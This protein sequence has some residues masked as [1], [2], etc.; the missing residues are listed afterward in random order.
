MP[1]LT[2]SDIAS[3]L[4]LPTPGAP[5]RPVSGV[6]TLAEASEREISFL[7]SE[8]YLDDFAASKAAAVLVQ[9][10]VKLPPDHGKLVFFVDDADLAVAKL[11]E[12]FAPPVPRPPVGRDHTA[13]VAPSAS[14][15]DGARI[16]PNVFVG[17]ACRIGKNVVLHA[18]VYV[19][20]DVTIGD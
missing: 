5:T 9:K 8:K 1:A 11:L 20:C 12:H 10:R 17:D 13:C 6:S 4:N 19:G 3:I 7:G 2:L 15:A 16:G 18:G 14:V